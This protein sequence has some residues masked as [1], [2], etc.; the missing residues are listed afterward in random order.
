M[1]AESLKGMYLWAGLVFL[2]LTLLLL[3]TPAIAG[4]K[5]PAKKP[6][7]TETK[8]DPEKLKQLKE[9]QRQRE[10]EEKDPSKKVEDE[11]EIEKQMDESRAQTIAKKKEMQPERDALAKKQ[12]DLAKK[13]KKLP[14]DEQER[15]EE[16][17]KYIA[18]Q[19]ERL[20]RADLEE[21]RRIDNARTYGSHRRAIQEYLK[22]YQDCK[23][24]RELIK[25]AHWRWVEEYLVI[26]EK[27][28]AERY[29]KETGDYTQEEIDAHERQSNEG[30]RRLDEQ[31]H[32]ELER[33]CHPERFKPKDEEEYGMAP[34]GYGGYLEGY[35]GYAGNSS[36]SINPAFNTCQ[37][38]QTANFRGT[39]D[40][41]VA[42]GVRLGLWFERGGLFGQSL[43]TWAQYF[44][45]YTDFSYHRLNFAQQG[46]GNGITTPA[47]FFSSEGTAATWSFMFAGRYGFLPDQEVPFGRLQPYVGVGPGILFTSQTPTFSVTPGGGVPERFEPGSQSATVVC[48][49]VDAG[50]RYMALRNVFID[51]F[52]KYRRAQPSFTYDVAD[53]H[54]GLRSS[55]TLSPT[56][57][58]FSANVGVG[59]LF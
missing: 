27:L 11:A 32:E 17:D 24:A 6:T 31:L 57:D 33:L 2:A 26:Q 20:K 46:H 14:W 19:D 22:Q 55:V 49:T 37:G 13:G 54:N 39:M 5:P 3:G 56:L 34:R 48:L 38:L 12:E 10:R 47:T 42:G 16:L 1:N 52:F 59:I 43:P 23:G 44:G 58:L 9:I 29:S 40:P 8:T 21:R 7:K 15:L 35:L 30:L 18:Q 4:D 36:S 28:N 51:V 45:V 25:K 41:S 53:P 50:V